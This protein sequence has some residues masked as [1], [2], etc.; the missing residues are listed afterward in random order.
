[1]PNSLYQP[2]LCIFCGIITMGISRCRVDKRYVEVVIT[3]LYT[4]HP[5]PFRLRSEKGCR[6]LLD[7][8]KWE[9]HDMRCVVN[10]VWQYF[11]GALVIELLNFTKIYVAGA[12]GACRL[13]QGKTVN[14]IQIPLLYLLCIYFSIPR[15]RFRKVLLQLPGR[16]TVSKRTPVEGLENENTALYK[17]WH[18]YGNKKSHT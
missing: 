9:T 7:P 5:F 11:C 15:L 13:L 3:L 2:P 12:T 17:I 8:R 10:Q 14:N 6:P 18:R 4:P 1:M 16:S